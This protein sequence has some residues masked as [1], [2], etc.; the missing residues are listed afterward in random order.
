MGDKIR[1]AVIGL[2]VGMAHA[3]GYRANPN[4][5]LIAV[6]DADPARLHLRGTELGIPPERQFCD[7]AE[8]LRLPELDAVSIGL[9]N[10]LHAPVGIAAL[11]AGKHVLCEKPLA[12]SATEAAAMVDAARLNGRELMVCFNYRFRDDARWLRDMGNAGRMGSVY[13]ARAGWLRNTGIPGFG[14]WF[15]TRAMSGGGPL[16]DLGVHIL[17]LTLWLMNY[18]RPV[19]V[20]GQTF[21]TFGPRGRKAWGNKPPT[22]PAASLSGAFDVEDLA[23]GFVRFDNGAALQIETS[24]ASH[25]K[26][27]RDDYFIHLYGDEGG[28]DLYVANY[29]DRDTLRFYTED[30]GQ[31]VVLQPAIINRAAGH[32]LAVAHFVD[33]LQSGR[34]VESTGAQGQALMQIIDALYESSATGREVR[35]D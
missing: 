23:A 24:W 30:C 9:P 34:P 32:E 26:P 3:R 2:G 19:A 35:L 10:Y 15:T 29:T 4:A 14:G 5:E 20:S 13:Y 16:I 31:P 11:Q 6:C 33:C 25:T 7:Y 21:S 17:D 1:A 22:G 28:A 27:G 8:L 18:P 12:C